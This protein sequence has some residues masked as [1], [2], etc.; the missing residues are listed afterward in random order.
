VFILVPSGSIIKTIVSPNDQ[1][2]TLHGLFPAR[3][4]F[5]FLYQGQR[6]DEQ[7]TFGFYGLEPNST[8]IALKEQGQSVYS[9]EKWLKLSSDNEEFGSVVVSLMN[10]QTRR[11]AMRVRDVALTKREMRPG[12]MRRI[13]VGNFIPERTM[14][15]DFPTRL[16]YDPPR[17]PSVAPL[18][19]HPIG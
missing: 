2:Q 17:G 19:T 14:G 12:R 10:P 11:E 3:L 5:A 9:F 15:S 6:M 1:C 7:Q 4:Q 8:I 16:D 13:F 18:P